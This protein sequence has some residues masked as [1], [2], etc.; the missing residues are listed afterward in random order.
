MLY[1]NPLPYRLPFQSRDKSFSNHGR[2]CRSSSM[3]GWNENTESVYK[4]RWNPHQY[5]YYHW[6][7][8]FHINN[9]SWHKL[10]SILEMNKIKKLLTACIQLLYRKPSNIC[11][12]IFIVE[13]N[14]KSAI[15]GTVKIHR[16]PLHITLIWLI[17]SDITCFF[18]KIHQYNF[19]DIFIFAGFRVVRIIALHKAKWYLWYG[20]SLIFDGPFRF[21]RAWLIV[22]FHL[23]NNNN[24]FVITYVSLV[25]LTK[26]ACSDENLFTK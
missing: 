23:Y 4:I 13:R 21:T 7:N 8:R 15:K 11:F 9:F 19:T 6:S 5:M 1:F 14:V 10:S 17:A 2:D 16:P 25:W 22:R 20:L 18:K 24:I 26:F 3:G 12:V